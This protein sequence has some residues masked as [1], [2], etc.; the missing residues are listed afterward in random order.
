[1]ENTSTIE[2][3]KIKITFAKND[4]HVLCNICQASLLYMVL[5]SN[6][7]LL[8]RSAQI[9]P[10]CVDETIYI[11]VLSLLMSG[12]ILSSEKFDE[13]D[14]I[15]INPDFNYTD[16][17]VDLT[18]YYKEALLY[19]QKKYLSQIDYIKNII[20][21]F[22]LYN[23]DDVHKKYWEIKHPFILYDEK[24]LINL[25]IPEYQH[26]NKNIDVDNF[27][28]NMDEHVVLEKISHESIISEN[29]LEIFDEVNVVS[30]SEEFVP[31]LITNTIVPELEEF[32]PNLTTDIKDIDNEIYVSIIQSNIDVDE[33]I[34]CDDPIM[35]I[36]YCNIMI[37][38]KYEL[39]NLLKKN[40][41]INIWDVYKIIYDKCTVDDVAINGLLNNAIRRTIKMM[42]KNNILHLHE[43]I[44]YNYDFWK[45]YGCII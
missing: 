26:L 28:F 45:E 7:N 1:M 16:A 20:I 22:K 36:K 30:E 31:E 27:E 41:H 17:E 3:L 4:Y 40:N 19:T 35:H 38:I 37:K 33:T 24:S 13:H 14:K 5:N 34:L 18:E 8:F 23:F 12:I 21:Q 39:N 2:K 10:F 42:C 9:K 15:C 32:T 29:V 43:N 11:A 6:N 44:L 25:V